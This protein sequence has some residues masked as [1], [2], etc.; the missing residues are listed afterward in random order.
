M[1]K[2]WSMTTIFFKRLGISLSAWL[3][4]G[5]LSRA[6]IGAYASAVAGDASLLCATK[7]LFASLVEERL[8]LTC[9]G[10]G[11]YSATTGERRS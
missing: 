7:S 5:L 10:R 3:L 6:M 1:H 11:P 8:A 2:P 9:H 4:G